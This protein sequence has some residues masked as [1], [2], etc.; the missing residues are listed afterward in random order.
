[1]NIIIVGCG[2]VG[3]KLISQ[4]SHERVEKPSDVVKE[5]DS[6]CNQEWECQSL[7]RAW[8]VRLSTFLQNN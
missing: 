7:Y 3:R 4:L 1:M 5:G 8:A 2:K 6:V